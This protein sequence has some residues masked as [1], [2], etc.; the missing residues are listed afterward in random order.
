MLLAE[1][2]LRASAK[3]AGKDQLAL[4]IPM[5]ATHTLAIIVERVWTET[6][7]IVVS[8]LQVLQVQTAG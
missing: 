7:G 4:R 3:K 6:T 1:I 8:V 2:L 5:I